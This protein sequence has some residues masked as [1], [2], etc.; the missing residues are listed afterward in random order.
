M[1]ES[2]TNEIVPHQN[3]VIEADEMFQSTLEKE[4]TQPES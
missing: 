4:S 1:A 3:Q 2:L